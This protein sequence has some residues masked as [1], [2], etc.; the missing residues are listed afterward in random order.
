MQVESLAL[1]H[2]RNYDAL[3]LTLK[4]YQRIALIGLNA[5]GKSS[6]LESL[7]VL[8]F[9]SSFRSS[10][11]VELIQWQSQLARLQ[12]ICRYE[13]G[14]E[15]TLAFEVQQDG[16]RR[17][18]VNHA[19]QKRLQ[20]YVGCL[21]LVLFS[22]QDLN[23][24]LGQPAKRR[25][26][27]D[28]LMVQIRPGY[29]ALLHEYHRVLRQRNSLLK[30]LKSSGQRR[31]SGQFEQLEL[32]DIQLSQAA[33]KII[34]QRKQVLNHLM[35]LVKQT[36]I[37]ISGLHEELQAEYK[38]LVD[39]APEAIC[40]ALNQ[41]HQRDI[42]M[43]QTSIGPHRDDLSFKM[44]Q[45]DLKQVGSQGQIRTA[46]LAMKVAELLYTRQSIGEYPILLLDDVFS[47]LDIHRQQTL[48]D[49]ISIPGLQT[50]L[51]TTHLEGPIKR[52]FDEQGLIL[53]VHKGQIV[54]I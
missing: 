31:G 14:D 21:K 17:V 8:A 3:N 19:Y 39:P 20:D 34:Q 38:T 9:A 35:Q 37:A 48:V 42:M 28:L 5:Q 4:N 15:I 26:F 50:F 25:L 54:S 36:H 43:G 27:I 41:R 11:P 30:E 32:W 53:H 24:V 23:L 16:K 44:N 52:L 29:Y 2:F 33:A 12:T 47:E 1:S 6:F 45:R 46:V 7:Y 51:T 22:Q 40:K 10:Q 13:R 18:Q 49:Q